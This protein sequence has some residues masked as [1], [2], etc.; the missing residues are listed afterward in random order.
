[1]VDEKN[2]ATPS[3]WAGGRDPDPREI[4]RL[5]AS[6]RSHPLGLPF[7]LDGHLGSVAVTFGA[8]AFDVEAAR[9]RL[10]ESKA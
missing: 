2:R 4:E 8:H 6:A 3:N 5:I 7:L 1:M 10:R 9:E